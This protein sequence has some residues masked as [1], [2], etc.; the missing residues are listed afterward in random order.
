MAVAARRLESARPVKTTR[1]RLVTNKPAA[2]RGASR[3]PRG[4]SR[5]TGRTS[6]RS[7]AAAAS[8]VQR[9]FW[10]FLCIVVACAAIGILRV[11]FTAHAADSALA[12]YRLQ[13]VIRAERYEADILSIKSSALAT[14]SRIEAIA[15]STMGMSPAKQV[16][17]IAAPGE[18]SEENGDGSP[19]DNGAGFG[20]IVSAVFGGSGSGSAGDSG[21]RTN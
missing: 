19:Q 10:T 15:V 1:L 13:K 14:P 12:S 3:A 9:A 6:T 20:T 18:A 2:K 5:V 21:A 4:A 16:S 8:G 7:R 17:Y 11:Y